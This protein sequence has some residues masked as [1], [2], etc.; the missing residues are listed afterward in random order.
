MTTQRVV[1]RDTDTLCE[2]CGGRTELVTLYATGWDGD[3]SVVMLM[4]GPSRQCADRGCPSRVREAQ[5]TAQRAA[6]LQSLNPR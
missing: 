3:D 2:V 5:V 6:L 1:E 4:S